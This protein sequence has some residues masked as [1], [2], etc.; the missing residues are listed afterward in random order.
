MGMNAISGG[1]QAV[2]LEVIVN[3]NIILKVKALTENLGKN[4]IKLCFK[5]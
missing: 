5:I 4:S 1:Q 2:H 3:G